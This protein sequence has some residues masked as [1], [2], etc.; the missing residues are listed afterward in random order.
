MNEQKQYENRDMPF[1]EKSIAPI[2]PD[3]VL[4]FHTH[5][6]LYNQWLI[7]VREKRV[8]RMPRL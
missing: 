7:P 6:W 1:Y 3:K 8:Q 5:A 4:D 2:L